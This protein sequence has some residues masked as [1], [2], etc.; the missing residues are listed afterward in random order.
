VNPQAIP[1]LTGYQSGEASLM[2]IKITFIRA[3]RSI[4][5]ALSRWGSP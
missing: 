3:A 2:P 1:P 5:I 4:M